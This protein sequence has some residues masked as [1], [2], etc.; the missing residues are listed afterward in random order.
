MVIKQDS[1][2][3][4]LYSES[5]LSQYAV[6]YVSAQFRA[7]IRVGRAGLVSR[8]LDDGGSHAN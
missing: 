5:K 6:I 1:R 8:A 7:E 2:I 4:K 3:K